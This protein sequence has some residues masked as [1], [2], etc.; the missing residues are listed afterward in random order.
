MYFPSPALL[1][2]YGSRIIPLEKINLDEWDISV[3]LNLKNPI[4]FPFI[5]V[6][7]LDYFEEKIKNEYFDDD[8]YTIYDFKKLISGMDFLHETETLLEPHLVFNFEIINKTRAKIPTFLF[9][10][11]IHQNLVGMESINDPLLSILITNK[12]RYLDMSI[13]FSIFFQ[14]LCAYRVLLDLNPNIVL[15]YSD[16]YVH[17]LG[18]Q[19]IIN[20]PIGNNGFIKIKTRYLLRCNV[21]Q[22]FDKTIIPYHQSTKLLSII[23]TIC[24]L[25]IYKKEILSCFGIK[26][27]IFSM[28]ADLP[29][30]I[31]PIDF[32]HLCLTKP[33]LF[34]GTMHE[35]EF[36]NVITMDG[37][38]LEYSNLKG[39]NDLFYPTYDISIYPKLPK[40]VSPKIEKG[41]IPSFTT[42][43]KR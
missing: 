5:Y 24:D 32:I 30:D 17:D 25:N 26:R 9:C 37:R 23:N 31:D 21:H 13:Y 3:E 35:I 16:F 12:H 42:N 10:Y 33:G 29:F 41:R 2:K 38:K 15:V 39:G 34:D 28:T 20:F 18:N 43:N 19:Y 14:Y 36:K 7:L 11:N 27:N 4:I 6:P 1:E 40:I 8:I 22:G